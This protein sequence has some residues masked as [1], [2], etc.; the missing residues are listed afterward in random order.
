VK[1]EHVLSLVDQARLSTLATVKLQVMYLFAQTLSFISSAL[2]AP[3]RFARRSSIRLRSFFVFLVVLWD[4][5]DSIDWPATY[6][7]YGLQ[8]LAL[9]L[10]DLLIVC[11]AIAPSRA[12]LGAG[13]ALL[14][15]L[16]KR[17]L[18]GLF[19]GLFFTALPK[20]FRL[21]VPLA[22][23]AWWLVFS[24]YKTPVF[25]MARRA[26]EVANVKGMLS[27]LPFL[28]L[29]IYLLTVV[30]LLVFSILSSISSSCLRPIHKSKRIAN[31]ANRF[32]A[33][34]VSHLLG[35]FWRTAFTAREF[36]VDG[37]AP[38]NNMFT[39]VWHFVKNKYD[40]LGYDTQRTVDD[41]IPWCLFF[42]VIWI[43]FFVFTYR[44]E[45]CLNFVMNTY[46]RSVL[47]TAVLLLLYREGWNFVK[48]AADKVR[49]WGTRRARDRKEHKKTKREKKMEL[50]SGGAATP[51]NI[52][53]DEEEEDEE[54]DSQGRKEWLELLAEERRKES[55][56]RCCPRCNAVVLKLAGCDSMVCGRDYHGEAGSK[57]TGCGTNFSFESAKAYKSDLLEHPLYAKFGGGSGAAKDMLKELFEFH[58]I[59]QEEGEEE[60]GGDEGEEGGE[61]GEE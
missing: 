4:T 11:A 36:V 3:F 48:G 17:C 43:S 60:G 27:G 32:V 22:R 20:L 39:S 58:K 42:L 34:P 13:D 29:R 25:V 45:N 7:R 55:S 15:L 18:P 49:A 12:Y 59:E 40:H 23:T 33:K 44:I 14:S 37:A 52:Q 41:C 16:F 2:L 5:R 57:K 31:F 38:V 50:T 53:E 28:L 21:V 46:R 35:G 1:G 6:R 26:A 24:S 19:K 54:D 8:R 61:P 56:Y 47:G 10:T 9:R 51:L 30:V